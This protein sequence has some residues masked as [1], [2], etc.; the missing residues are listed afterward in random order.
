M[1]FTFKYVLISGTRTD[2]QGPSK[3]IQEA[4]LFLEEAGWTVVADRT[5]Q[6]GNAN[7]ALTHKMV[8]SS[9]GEAAGFPTY[10]LTIFSGTGAGAALA[11]NPFLMHT[12][13]DVGTNDVP[14]SGAGSHPAGSLPTTNTLTMGVNVDT[15]VWMSGDSEGVTFVSHQIGAATRDSIS[16]GKFK[17]FQP[18]EV[19]PYGLY[20]L[21]NNATAISAGGTGSSR[22]V[23][24]NPPR[25]ST[26][27]TS[28]EYVF[29]GILP[30]TANQPYDI[31]SAT[32]IFYA[33]PILGFANSTT[34]RNERGVVGM[35]QNAWEGT[36]TNGGMLQ[37]STLTAS[38]IG[39][40][41]IYRA[42]T[43]GVNNSLIIRQS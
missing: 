38:G 42:F 3:F 29:L 18:P 12:A 11:D 14:A 43:A 34:G 37:E 6:A 8:F 20:V 28:T 36:G 33:T 27:N 13:Y 4:R 21:G 24:G 25:N 5:T 30:S 32:S 10:Y 2:T 9:N 19:E 7:P 26:T 22:I 40:V 35:V 41:Q 31:G 39:G 16:V 1:P 17:V 23:T 15:E